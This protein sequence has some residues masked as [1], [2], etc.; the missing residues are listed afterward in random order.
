MATILEK[1]YIAA[2]RALFDKVYSSL[3]EKQR[4]AVFTVNTPL[5]I[6]AGAGS[7]KTTVLAR[8]IAY[9]IKYGNAYSSER[10]PY[11]ITEEKVK[12]ME[13]AINLSR[14]EIEEILL[15]FIEDP[16]PPYRVLAITFTIK[17]AREIKTR[18]ADQLGDE[19]IARDIWSGTFHSICMRILRVYG[20]RIGYGKEFTIYD[21]DDVKKTI[22]AVMKKCGVDDKQFPIK[23]VINAISR[24]KDELKTP[25]DLAAEAGADFRVSKIAKIYA[26][27]RDELKSSNAMDFDDIIMQTVHLLLTCPDVLEYYQRKF[28]Y[29]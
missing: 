7:G 28:K 20:E 5:L 4:E 13:D 8:R 10:V 17:A 1:R 9:I 6:L 3:N 12:E 18:L 25:E 21:T 11:G 23:S 15:E 14:E 19:M 24:A 27:Y 26:A 29:V 22:T 2:K 16:C